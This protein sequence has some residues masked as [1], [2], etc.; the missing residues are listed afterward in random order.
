MF[1]LLSTVKRFLS[2]RVNFR[3]QHQYYTKNVVCN[4]ILDDKF[5]ILAPKSTVF[6]V[7]DKRLIIYCFDEKPIYVENASKLTKNHINCLEIHGV[8]PVYWVYRN[9]NI[10]VE[11]V[12][13]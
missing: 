8:V 1:K 7:D 12:N 2:K 3:K 4:T 10:D 6:E 9:L 5:G 11:Y 13:Y